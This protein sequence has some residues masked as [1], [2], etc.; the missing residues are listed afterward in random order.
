MAD[1]NHPVVR[2]SN[3]DGVT[4]VEILRREIQGP[5]AAAE[6]GGEL[7]SLLRSGQKRLLLDFRNT[8]IMSSTA[9]GTLLMFSKQVEAAH[10]ELR[11]CSMD[12]AVRFGAD[13]LSLGRY[14]PIHDDEHSALAAFKGAPADG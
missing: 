11:I 6:L 14:I 4:K 7:T 9:F 8:R 1:A 2:A 5:D 10:G 13:I 3:V 12:S